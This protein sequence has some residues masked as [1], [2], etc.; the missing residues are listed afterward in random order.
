MF[1]NTKVFSHLITTF[2]DDM[3]KRGMCFVDNLPFYAGFYE[4]G[5]LEK[6]LEKIK[7]NLVYLQAGNVEALNEPMP[8]LL[9]VILPSKRCPKEYC[10]YTH[11]MKLIAIHLAEIKTKCEIEYGWMTQCLVKKTVIDYWKPLTINNVCLKINAK[12]GGTNWKVE[13]NSQR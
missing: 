13:P 8:D 11:Y 12:M 2:A 1:C 3:N 6:T 9:I 10:K 4:N 5:K 7:T